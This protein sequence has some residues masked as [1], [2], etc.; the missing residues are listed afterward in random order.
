MS[1]NKTLASIAAPAPEVVEQVVEQKQHQSAQQKA[2]FDKGLAETRVQR[3]RV[4][5]LVSHPRL[6][7]SCPGCPCGRH[8]L[9]VLSIKVELARKGEPSPPA[10]C[11]G[12]GLLGVPSNVSRSLML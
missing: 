12:Q 1:T 7:V 8:T 4:D 6:P 11:T 2:R 10:W 9:S 5:G 3:V